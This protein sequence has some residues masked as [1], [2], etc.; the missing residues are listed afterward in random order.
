[1]LGSPAEKLYQTHCFE[2]LQ[3]VFGIKNYVVST[4]YLFNI[5]PTYIQYKSAL[6]IQYNSEKKLV[7]HYQ[8]LH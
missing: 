8:E 4:R 2:S 7:L 1:M 6:F 5:I 3:Q